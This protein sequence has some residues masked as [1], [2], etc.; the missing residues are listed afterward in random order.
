MAISRENFVPRRF[1]F[2]TGLAG[3]PGGV[4]VGRDFKRGVCPTNRGACGG[5]FVGAQ[6]RAVHIGTIGLVRRTHTD[7]GTTADQGRTLGISFGS[8]DGG[9]QCRGIMTIDVRNH[10]PAIGG[11]AARCVVGEPAFNLTIDRDAVVV[12]ERN[13]FAQTERTG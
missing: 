2:G 13:Q 6:R 12:P 11:K 7:R 9:I 4:N 8:L 5:N 1:A 10:L 3:I